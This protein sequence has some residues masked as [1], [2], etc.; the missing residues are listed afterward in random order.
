MNFSWIHPTE[1]EDM[2]DSRAYMPEYLE[3][4]RF[5]KNLPIPKLA[6][7]TISKDV[8]RGT[9]PPYIER[10]NWNIDVPKVLKTVNV[11][12]NLLDMA[13]SFD[14]EPHVYQSL[15]RFSVSEQ[16]VLIT[17]MGATPDVIGRSW[18]YSSWIGKA[19]FSERLL[20]LS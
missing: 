11:R 20:S 12:E 8:Y 17:I 15:S 19:C 10:E 7:G 14:V 6:I 1:L 13:K 16:D 2:L 5:I 3:N 4:D 18:S 9:T